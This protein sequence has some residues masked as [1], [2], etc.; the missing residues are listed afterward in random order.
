MSGVVKAGKRLG[1]QLT[2]ADGSD[3]FESWS[4]RNG[5]S[6]AEGQWSQWV[7]LA[8]RILQD[9]LTELV[10]P[11]ARTAVARLELRDFYDEVD[12]ELTEDQIRERFKL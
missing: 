7:D 9:P 10:R 2:Y 4:P 6:N 11:E 3:W 1:V 12:V 5:N 8:L